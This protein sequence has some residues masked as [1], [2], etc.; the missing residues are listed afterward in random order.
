MT[1]AEDVPGAGPVYRFAAG[2]AFGI[3]GS[4]R[5]RFDAQGTENIPRSGG[6]VV[7]YNHSSYWD[8]F[9]VG[10][11]PYKH[12]GRPIRILAKEQLFRVPVFGWLMK[13]ARHI[14]VHRGRGTDAL[15][16]AV[17]ALRG[18]ELVCIA[19]EQTISPSFEL[20][21]FKTGAVRMAAAAG[22]PI[23]PV[24]SWGTHRF[25]TKGHPLR[26][27][28]KLPVTVRYGEPLEVGPD[29][30]PRSATE[31]LRS[32]IERLLHVAQ[33]EYP[34]QPAPGDAWW[35]P[36]RLGGTAPPH[37]EVLAEHAEQDRRWRQAH[38]EATGEAERDAS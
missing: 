32:A 30:D 12:L 31:R 1:P 4:Q 14:P 34:V 20:L 9:T 28:W 15:R 25:H 22:V 5:W 16:S 26:P 13:R 8:Y 18:G 37:D 36:R 17:E 33:E 35:L 21:P 7:A 23:V 38:P 2:A 10:R 6:A 24:A 29:E 19:P 3:M 27:R 11:W